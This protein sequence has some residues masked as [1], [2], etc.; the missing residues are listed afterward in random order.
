MS[1]SAIVNI[2]ATNPQALATTDTP[3]FAGVNL[4]DTN[5][6]DYKE[7]TWTPKLYAGGVEITSYYYQFGWY[8]KIGRVVYVNCQI[9]INA[10]GAVTGGLT[11]QNLPFTSN[12]ATRNKSLAVLGGSYII[13]L[14]GQHLYGLIEPGTTY[15]DL[16]IMNGDTGNI[17]Q[18]TALQ[19]E[20]TTFY[21]TG[22]Y[23]V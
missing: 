8:T 11:I 4:G 6:N 22:F 23:I 17:I 14:T 10:I 21:L 20:D 2:V 7:G 16:Y 13:G 3:I 18:Y 1:N 19:A 9:T 12:S 5:L 15:Y